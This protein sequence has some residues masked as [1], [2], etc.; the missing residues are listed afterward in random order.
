MGKGKKSEDILMAYCSCF[1]PK[2][3]YILEAVCN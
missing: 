2:Y 3:S 1:M